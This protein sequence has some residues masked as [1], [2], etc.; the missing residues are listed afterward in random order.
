MCVSLPDRGARWKVIQCEPPLSYST[1]RA[2]R[3]HEHGGYR[4]CTRERR[5]LKCPPSFVMGRIY[6]GIKQIKVTGRYRWISGKE[7]MT[8]A[9]VCCFKA[10]LLCHKCGLTQIQIGSITNERSSFSRKVN[11]S[12]ELKT[13]LINSLSQKM[14]QVW[15]V[16]HHELGSITK[17]LHEFT[18]PIITLTAHSL[19]HAIVLHLLYFLSVPNREEARN[20]RKGRQN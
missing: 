6:E 14:A 16:I 8:R 9:E 7:W 13:T 3:G 17:S 19:S 11:S 2:A 20:H 10:G 1:T 5:A 15:C 12:L 4:I 18:Q